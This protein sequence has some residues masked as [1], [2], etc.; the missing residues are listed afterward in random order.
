MD[1]SIKVIFQVNQEEDVIT[2]D[3]HVNEIIDGVESGKKLY[4]RFI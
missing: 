3:N 1:K 2:W 4:L